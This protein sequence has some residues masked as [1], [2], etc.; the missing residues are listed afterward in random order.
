MYGFIAYSLVRWT[1]TWRNRLNI[2]FLAIVLIAAIGFSRL[3][4]GVHFFSDVLGGYL[5]GSLWLIIGV[6]IAELSAD[7]EPGPFRPLLS[8]RMLRNVTVV[9]LF[10]AAAFYVCTGVRYHPAG[11]ASAREKP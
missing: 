10:L 1:G 9:I 3:Y 2:S 4:L 8:P 5:L 6:C 11:Q 7:R